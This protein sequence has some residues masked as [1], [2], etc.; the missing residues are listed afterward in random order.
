MEGEVVI[1]NRSLIWFKKEG[2][3]KNLEQSGRFKFYSLTGGW[4]DIIKAGFKKKGG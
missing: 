3:R 2:L 4:F 1:G